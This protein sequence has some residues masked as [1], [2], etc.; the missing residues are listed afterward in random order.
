MNS[1]LS[2]T[3]P[4]SVLLI[5]DQVIIAEA[6]RRMLEDQK[7]IAFHYCQDPSKAIAMASE[8]QPTVILQDLVMPEMDGL[9]LLRYFRAN[10]GTLDVPLIVLSMKE[11][12]TLKAEAFA[13]GANDYIVK[14]PDKIELIA[15]IRYHSTAYTRLLE[16]NVAYEKLEENQKVLN[17]DLAEAETYVRSL[18]PAPLN[19]GL[20]ITWKYIPSASLG[21]DAF[22][23][24]WID[25]D[26][27]SIYLLDVC[28]HG[29]GAALLSITI[30]NV[31]GSESLPDVNFRD[32]SQVLE[33]LNNTFPMEKH[34]GM[35][36]TLWYGVY[37]KKK[38]EIIYASGGHP[39]AILFTGKTPEE[40]VT[41]EL[42]TPGLVIGGMV[43][44]K[45]PSATYPLGKFSKLY[46]FSDGVFELS[47][48]SGGM[49]NFGEF[50]DFLRMQRIKE[51]DN[52]DA[53]IQFA[54][55]INGSGSFPDDVSIVEIL[56]K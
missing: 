3:F 25:E 34:N 56:F 4:I 36:F 19:N 26:H 16:R 11:E 35:F 46:V 27:F 2:Q 30:M 42:S 15:R 52:L 5:D 41:V 10:P 8:V 14:L 38:R 7:D 20:R 55:T 54:Q 37:N 45:F 9:T 23:Y 50:V 31:L 53:V 6:V 32:P 28:G 44:M 17:D 49:L 33:M 24:H 39:P 40:A 43:G 18:L 48:S 22:G 12:S 13:L 51:N 1:E 29:V 47:K 21:G